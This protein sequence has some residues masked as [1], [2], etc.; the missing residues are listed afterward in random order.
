MSVEEEKALDAQIEELRGDL[1]ETA[2][3]FFDE[4]EGSPNHGD[5]VP[6][7]RWCREHPFED[8]PEPF[9]PEMRRYGHLIARRRALRSQ[10]GLPSDPTAGKSMTYRTIVLRGD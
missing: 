8:D 3:A 5:I 7:S 2:R 6:V 4:I 1:S 10:G 9:T